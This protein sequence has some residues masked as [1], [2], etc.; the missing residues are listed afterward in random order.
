MLT[1]HC[2]KFITNGA[3]VFAGQPRF[4]KLVGDCTNQETKGG[5]KKGAIGPAG[6]HFSDGEWQCQIQQAAYV[7]CDQ[8]T[9]EVLCA[10]ADSSVEQFDGIKCIKF[11]TF[12]SDWHW[13]RKLRQQKCSPHNFV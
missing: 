8:E 6:V 11:E 5:L 2:A 13:V 4:V 1:H 3:S 10:L 9:E 12:L 7:M